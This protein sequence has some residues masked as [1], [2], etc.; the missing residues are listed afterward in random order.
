[1][2]LAFLPALAFAAPIFAQT[3]DPA[4]PHLPPSFTI[5]TADQATVEKLLKENLQKLG[6]GKNLMSMRPESVC[7]VPLVR[8][9]IPRPDQYADRPVKPSEVESIPKA[10]LPAPPCK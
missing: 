10:V 7:S 5:A 8:A 4:P 3:Q 6:D 2:R 9:L 1:M